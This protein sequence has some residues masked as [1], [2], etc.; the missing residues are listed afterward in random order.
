M[1]HLNLIPVALQWIGVTHLTLPNCTLQIPR[2][3]H[4]NQYSVPL[5]RHVP[6]CTSLFNRSFHPGHVVAHVVLGGQLL[7][8]GP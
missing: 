6:E 5:A 8:T 3:T 2:V 7:R 4:L 1:T